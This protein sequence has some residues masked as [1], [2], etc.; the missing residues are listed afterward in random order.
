MRTQ[1]LL[2]ISL[3]RIFILC[4]AL[5]ISIPALAT[6][7]QKD[8]EVIEEETLIKDNGKQIKT[9]RVGK[10]RQRKGEMLVGEIEE[11]E[12][13]QIQRRQKSLGFHV[14]G[15]GPAGSTNVGDNKMLYHLSYGYHWEVSTKAEIT[16]DM[17][18]AG[19]SQGAFG[20]AG[21]GF[22]YLPARGSISPLIGLALGGGYASG[23]DLNQSGFTGQLNLGVRMFRLSDTQM[24]FLTS[25]T[26]ILAEGNLSL[27]GLQIR[28]LY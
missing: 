23:N 3:L 19:N 18:A 4:N 14:F 11:D 5:A 15:F 16:A 10:A 1:I 7:F 13:S 2:F 28:I 22:S 12:I 25:Y 27:Y 17:L 20:N 9:K 21:L 26:S 6:N 8:S 24:E